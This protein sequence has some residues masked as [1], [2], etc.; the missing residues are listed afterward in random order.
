M[1][2]L[3]L[4][5]TLMAIVI[6]T[7]TNVHAQ[8]DSRNFWILNNTGHALRS[9][10]V[11]PH[12]SGQWGSDTLGR[13]TLDLGMGT[14]ISFSGRSSCVMDFKLVFEDGT[15]KTDEEGMN[16]CGL[17]AVLLT[18]DKLFAIPLP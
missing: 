2:N 8:R 3:L 14:F 4:V 1:K 15:R 10:Y 18:E 7:G 11:S 12:E 17:A 16:V 6:S 5:M 13:G 9:L